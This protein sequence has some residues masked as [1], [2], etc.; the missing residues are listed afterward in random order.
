MLLV[1]FN[2][3]E[4]KLNK[5]LLGRSE[6]GIGVLGCWGTGMLDYWIIGVLGYWVTGMEYWN[7][8]AGIIG[9]ME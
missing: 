8:G 7:G 4:K 5:V 1:L 9:L 3:S 6:L 2:D